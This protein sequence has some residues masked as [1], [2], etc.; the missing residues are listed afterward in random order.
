[1][2]DELEL[3]RAA[4]I[5]HGE[6]LARQPGCGGIGIGVDSSSKPCMKIFTR[7]MSN[8]VRKSIEQR[9]DGVNIEFVEIGRVEKL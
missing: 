1:M 7:L 4:K 3:V 6:W 2:S 8:D 9:L 5:L